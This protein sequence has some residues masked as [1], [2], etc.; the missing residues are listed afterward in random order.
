MK[1]QSKQLSGYLTG[2]MSSDDEQDK[3]EY[4]NTVCSDYSRESLMYKERI[5]SIQSKEEEERV[6]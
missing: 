5:Y 2:E 4:L 6:S 3:N 1:R